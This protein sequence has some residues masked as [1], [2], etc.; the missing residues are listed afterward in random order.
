MF[1]IDDIVQEGIAVGRSFAMYKNYNI[2]GNKEMI[3]IGT[4]NIVGSFTSCYLTTGKHHHQ[5]LTKTYIFSTS[6]PNIKGIKNYDSFRA[7]FA[8]GCELQCWMQ[9]CSIQHSDV[10]C[11]DADTVVF[12][13]F[14]LLHSSGGTISHNCI[15]NAWTYRLRSSHPS[16]ED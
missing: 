12:D 11:S 5:M 4:M 13:T 9:D 2:D 10:N 3:A 6:I 15:C 14:V 7:I 8:F 16:L 1:N